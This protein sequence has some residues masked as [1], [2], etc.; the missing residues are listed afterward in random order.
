MIGHEGIFNSLK[1]KLPPV[2]LFFGPTSVGKKALARELRMDLRILTSD[3]AW[4]YDLTVDHA[5]QLFTF[6][7]TAP[8]G[9]R[10]LAVITV[11]KRTPAGV[12]A[13]LR[14]LD[15]LPAT[16]HIIMI[17]S[18]PVPE[19]LVSR[20]FTYQFAL[21]S[22]DEVAEI[23]EI[24]HFG[25]DNAR[26]FA[27]LSGGQVQVALSAYELQTDKLPVLRVIEAFRERDAAI[28]ESVAARWT[29]RHTELLARWCHEAVTGRWRIFTEEEAGGI[30]RGVPLRIYRAIE[31]D[32]RPKLLIRSVLAEVLKE[33]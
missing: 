6:A 26:K 17:A 18:Q 28:L 13:L 25:Q 29:D 4:F 27:A 15:Q 11:D 2:S 8:V 3:F 23:L 24:R 33:L 32:V 16:S 20:S 12:N 5:T 30:D 1:E 14:A 19:T 10:R 21:L 31:Q 7:R 9:E 22:E